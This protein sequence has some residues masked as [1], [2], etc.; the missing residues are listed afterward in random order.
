MLIARLFF[1]NHALIV[2]LTH[3]LFVTFFSLFVLHLQVDF[4]SPLLLNASLLLVLTTDYSDWLVQVNELTDNWQWWSLLSVD[5]CAIEEL[6][7][8]SFNVEKRSISECLCS[9]LALLVRI[10]FFPAL[11]FLFVIN[12]L[13]CQHVHLCFYFCVVLCISV[14]LVFR[15]MCHS[16]FFIILCVLC[17]FIW[18]NKGIY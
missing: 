14:Y 12:P 2:V 9:L 5:D 1:F 15:P 8:C 7:I 3:I 4:V 18:R 10:I 6:I 16:V 13:M 11:E 17:A